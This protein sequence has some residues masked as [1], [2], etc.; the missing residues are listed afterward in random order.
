LNSNINIVTVVGK[1]TH[2]IFARKS[3]SLTLQELHALLEVDGFTYDDY[4]TNSRGHKNVRELMLELWKQLLSI[5]ESTDEP[6][7]D[8]NNVYKTVV[9]TMR[10]YTSFSIL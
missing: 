6:S 2:K 8:L 5:I 7:Q 1:P 9:A 10:R 4:N 3:A